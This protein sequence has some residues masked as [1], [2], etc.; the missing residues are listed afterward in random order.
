MISSRTALIGPFQQTSLRSSND[1]A[2][3]KPFSKLVQP[4]N[5]LDL[6][7]SS[8]IQA[9]VERLELARVD[10]AYNR[11]WEHPA[12][13]SPFVAKRAI[14]KDL[15][16]FESIGIMVLDAFN[17]H[18]GIKGWD[19]Q[20]VI[21]LEV[22]IIE[23]LLAAKCNQNLVYFSELPD[24]NKLEG[25]LPIDFLLPFKNLIQT[26]ENP[27]PTLALTRASVSRQDVALFEEI[28]VSKVFRQYERS[29]GELEETQVPVKAA[30]ESVRKQSYLLA[31][32]SPR[33]LKT[34]RAI[35]SL[36]PI[37]TKIVDTVFGKL[38]GSLA[39]FFAAAFTKWLQDNRRIVIYQL[40]DLRHQV[41]LARM[42]ECNNSARKLKKDKTVS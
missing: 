34:K 20:R 13:L 10:T 18:F 15:P 25:I 42:W 38:P 3:L 6:L 30:L 23:L 36:L 24:V 1:I 16:E 11:K 4:L 35:V 14:H 26:F 22:F 40:G 2:N 32:E 19:R 9:G 7:Y 12:D 39:E 33:L 17:N 37:T 31:A 29:Q 5:V 27:S 28:I 8:V 41:T 21:E